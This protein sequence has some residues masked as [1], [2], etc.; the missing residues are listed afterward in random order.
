MASNFENQ[1]YMEILRISKN[2]TVAWKTLTFSESVRRIAS[3]EYAHTIGCII[4]IFGKNLGGASDTVLLDEQD[5]VLIDWVQ[6]VKHF[7][8]TKKF[9]ITHVN[10]TT[11]KVSK[12]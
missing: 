6:S 8:K 2:S 3:A 9:Q 11:F 12:P 1:I 5:S 4:S 7:L 10:A